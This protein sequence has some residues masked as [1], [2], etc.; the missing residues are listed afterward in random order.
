LGAREL[1]AHQHREIELIY[2]REGRLDFFVNAVKYSLVRGDLLIIPPYA[3]HRVPA[4]SEGKTGHDCVCFSAT[5]LCDEALRTVLEG[6]PSLPARHVRAD[7]DLDGMYA[8]YMKNAFR[9][10]REEKEGWEL[11]AVGNLSLLFAVLKEEGT[12]SQ[13]GS[14]FGGATFAHDVIAYVEG[15]FSESLTSKDIA[16]FF[17]VSQSHF[18]RVFKDGF[19]TTFEKYLLAYRLECAR[20]LLYHG[21]LS[22]TE[23]AYKTGFHSGSYFGKTFRERYGETPLSYRNTKNSRK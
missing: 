3:I 16:D 1:I 15:H 21:E 14:A 13:E 23:I 5:L 6:T 22:V 19:G 4:H 12:F 7:E 20:A 2:V 18:C 8:A 9:A 17:H 10:C 11:V